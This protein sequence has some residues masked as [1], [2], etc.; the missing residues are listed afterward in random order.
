MRNKFFFGVIAATLLFIAA[1]GAS[2]YFLEVPKIFKFS[3]LP[4]IPS[5]VQRLAQNQEMAP[6]SGGASEPV[7]Q[8][9]PM[10]PIN[11]TERQPNNPAPGGEGMKA[12]MSN[13]DT[14]GKQ[15]C[16]IN[17]VEVPGRC[18]EV[19]NL[20]DEE[21][22]NRVK[23]DET[24]RVNDQKRGVQ[25][26]KMNLKNF[27]FTIKQ[28]VKQ[29][30]SISQEIKD[31]LEKAK[32][33]VSEI[34][35]LSDADEIQNKSDDLQ[36]IISNLED[37]RR[38]VAE[39]EL[40]LIQIRKDLKRMENEIKTFEK[41]LARLVKQKVVVPADVTE[42]LNSIKNIIKAIKNAK[43][44]EDL[45]DIDINEMH[46]LMGN[47]NE[48]RQK[49]EMLARWPQTL[50]QMDK[51]LARLKTELKRSK[52]IV[53]RL[54]KK[55]IDLTS[56][57]SE[58]ES[59]VGKLKTTRDEAA[60]KIQEGDSESAFE[61]VQEDFFGQMDDT[62]QNQR[63]I[64]EMSN[65]GRFS[66][67]FKKGIAQSEK[68]IK[69][70]KRRKMDTAGL[71]EMLTQAKQKGQEVLNT[72]K[73][74]PIDEETIFNDLQ[75]LENLK[76]EFD[77]ELSRLTG[78]EEVMP[79]EQGPQIFKEAPKVPENWSKLM[80]QKQATTETQPAPKE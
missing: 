37:Y 22:E 61:M 71:E 33:I 12:P 16:N 40:R 73:V 13:D 4:T 42:N 19:N 3:P 5:S 57:Y 67:D 18:D 70:L 1:P 50:K 27:E 80:P 46:N 60:A 69:D 54:I 77:K 15:T 31:K 23:Q 25:Q 39:N 75:E 29:G 47:L 66:S 24:R 36:E 30:V 32:N 26:M 6:T 9:Q 2:A 58:F 63:V 72:I 11:Q 7:Q 14:S 17:G 38:D 10:A 51:E 59:M 55:D 64:M 41:Q 52:V 48:S 65:L 20:S 49:L 35:S 68:T 44:A 8:V 74:S 53:D 34:E 76:Q 43:N 79:W 56:I 62:W 21:R 28:L 45:N 78:Q